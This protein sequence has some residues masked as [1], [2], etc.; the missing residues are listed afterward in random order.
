M[1]S[2]NFLYPEYG[3]I[4]LA[5]AGCTNR[6]S[7]WEVKCIGK[8]IFAQ[9]LGMTCYVVLLGTGAA[10]GQAEDTPRQT[11]LVTRIVLPPEADKDP[12]PPRQDT[13]A[14]PDA[15]K[16]KSPPPKPE[17]AEQQPEDAAGPRM[18]FLP[19]ADHQLPSVV[20]HFGASVAVVTR[21][22]Y[23]L[24]LKYGAP[25]RAVCIFETPDWT[26]AKAPDGR[27]LPLS[28]RMPL[29]VNH[30]ENDPFFRTMIEESGVAPSQ[31]RVFLVFRY[32]KDGFPDRLD[33]AI[34]AYGLR[35]TRLANASQLP[36]WSYIKL[37]WNAGED[38]GVSILDMAFAP[39]GERN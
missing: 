29:L 8:G 16:L 13:P 39:Q 5:A 36:P 1:E 25:L 21:D 9:A 2:P 33:Q 4:L 12:P 7:W 14:A 17:L 37:K 28:Q 35:K 26:P 30:A 3:E 24:S 10:M 20:R 23:N 11:T 15:A 32:I 22:D 27:K 18:E 38:A 31:A 6:H 19:D 34:A